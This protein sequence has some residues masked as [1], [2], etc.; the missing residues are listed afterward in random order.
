MLSR[1]LVELIQEKHK[2]ASAKVV[3]QWIAFVCIV[4]CLV[5]SLTVEKLENTMIWGLEF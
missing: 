2:R 5:S 4:G 3:I 1:K